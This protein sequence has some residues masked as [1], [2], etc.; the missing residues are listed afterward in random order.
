M[1]TGSSIPADACWPLR[2]TEL[3]RPETLVDMF[4][5]LRE[6]RGDVLELVFLNGCESEDL[7][8]A[9]HEQAKVPWVV[10]W[11]TKCNDEAARLFSLHF[12]EALRRAGALEAEPYPSAFYQAK[13]ALI[14]KHTR[15]GISADGAAA[16]VPK[17]VFRRI[18]GRLPTPSRV[19][20]TLEGL[21]DSLEGD[22]PDEPAAQPVQLADRPAGGPASCAIEVGEPLL[23]CPNGE[24][25]VGEDPS[26]YSAS[27]LG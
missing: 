8:H 3:V 18:E 1:P 9:L 15:V 16:Q 22:E 12:F 7:G 4:L 11:R 10:C 23:L 13:S 17:F 20:G 5:S 27:V 25:L 26:T 24:V 19:R 14:T 2:T 21:P 6:R